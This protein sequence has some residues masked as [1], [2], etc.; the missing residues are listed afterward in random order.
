MEAQY[1]ETTD[2]Q[3]LQS[4]KDW[5]DEEGW[6]RFHEKYGPLIMK[7]AERCG[8]NSGEASE[9]LQDTMV[10][11]SRY[12]PNFHY[13][14]DRCRFRVWLNTVVNHR[15]SE[16]MRRRRS[17]VR[18]SMM[19]QSLAA[20]MEIAQ[21][22]GEPEDL[23]YSGRLVLLEMVINQVRQEVSAARW[24]VFEARFLHGMSA[25]E[26]AERF[27]MSQVNVRVSQS[28]VL[29]KLREAWQELGDRPIV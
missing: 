2:P 20:E 4:I 26:I 16:A 22:T 12:V 18:E 3:I 17:R 21:A 5:R 1:S 27:Q 24:Q 29:A 25:R 10:K 19:L 7:H 14:R 15:I 28:R 11:V 8:L 9:V 6:R 13:D 23:G